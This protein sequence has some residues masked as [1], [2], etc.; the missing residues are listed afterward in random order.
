[1]INRLFISN[2]ALIEKAE[3]ELN[4]GFSV[5]TGETGAGKSILLGAIGLILGDRA[6]FSVLKDQ[7]KKCVIEGEFKISSYHLTG[8]FEE[9]D[10]DYDPITIIRREISSSGKSRA[11]IN[12]TPV[13]LVLL[14]DFASQLINIHSQNQTHQLKNEDFIIQLIDSYSDKSDLRNTYK[15]ELNHLKDLERK[16]QELKDSSQKLQAD[17]DYNRFQYEEIKTLKLKDIN[18]DELKEQV[19]FASNQEH[20]QSALESAL[21][22]M[23]QEDLGLIS[24]L[25]MI[26]S[27][28]H[29]IAKFN[30]KFE[31]LYQRI[32][33]GLIEMMDI[34][35]EL[36]NVLD[37]NQNEDSLELKI[38]VLDE[39]N[40][41]LQKHFLKDIKE[42]MDLEDDLATK[43]DFADNSEEMLHKLEQQILDRKQMLSD[44]G[45]QIHEDRKVIAKDLESELKTLLS[46]LVLPDATIRFDIEKVDKYSTTGM[47]QVRFLFN[48]NLGGTLTEISKSASGGETSRLMLAIQY[49]LSKKKSL[50]TLIFDEIDTGISGEIASKIGDL[51]AKISDNLQVI[52]ITHLPQVALKGANHYK[53][54]KESVLM[55]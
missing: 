7:E 3:I 18:F 17:A 14:K 4:T 30:S 43:I 6:D 11:F 42:L 45:S 29:S 26:R 25:Q 37:S 19:A 15:S 22:L 49:L 52:S 35:S 53:V 46:D 9:N 10:L 44:L 5:I 16:F 21:A 20:I 47:D 40:R 34:Q 39:I 50:S 1:M 24:N 31:D 12:D 8:F 41:L 13:N 33:S 48:A 27:Q 23:D 55:V 2:Y 51:L 38:E 36:S 28:I 32:D 54:Y